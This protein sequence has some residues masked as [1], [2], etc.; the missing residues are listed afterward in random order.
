MYRTTQ[1]R[2]P[3]PL[4]PQPPAPLRPRHLLTARTPGQLQER[5]DSCTVRVSNLSED[6]KDSDL[7]ELFRRFG[8]CIVVHTAWSLCMR[9]HVHV[10]APALDLL[11]LRRDA[12]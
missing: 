9:E 10:H 7:R 1:C 8:M 11:T 6:V 12:A 3:Q 5:D 2:T 4:H